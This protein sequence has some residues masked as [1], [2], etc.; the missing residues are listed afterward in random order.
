MTYR[1]LYPGIGQAVA[2]R[3]YLRKKTND[4]Y[5]NWGEVA[6][7]VALGNSLLCK[8][9]SEQKAEYEILKK[10][11]SNASILMSG[12]H[13]QHG[14]ESQPT[15][16]ME[17]FTNCSTSASCF[18]LFYLLMSGS[19]VGRCY[20]DDM[21]LVDWD[22]AP[23]LR[24]VL[25]D[26]H[27]DF[28]WSAHE[29]VR[30]AL[31]KYGPESKTV[32]WFKVPDSREG[33]AQAVEVWENAAF[34]KIHKDKT[35][36]LD[37]SDVRPKGSPIGGMQSRPSSGPIPLIN[38]L[39]K[40]ASL[41][42]SG[43]DPWKQNIY[44][45][46]YLAECVLVGGARRSA[47]MSTKFWK[48]ESIIDFIRVKR[49]IEFDGLS[50][51]E[52]LA[53]RKANPQTYGFL[54][55]SNNSVAVDEEFWK[56]LDLKRT[57]EAYGSPDAKWARKV[58]KE[59]INCS[60]ADG[61]GEP[62]IINVDK[63]VQ[64]NDGWQNLTG[65]SYV[66]SSKYQIREETEL[67]LGRLAKRAK[68]K[69]YNM[70]VNPC[71]EI[72]LSVLGG[73]CVIADVVPFHCDSLAEAREAFK[74]TTRAL[75]RV[76][77]MDA[78]YKKEVERT[79]RIGVGITGVHEFAWKFFK[80]GFRDLVNPNFEAIKNYTPEELENELETVTFDSISGKTNLGN[81][82]IRAALFWKCMEMFNGIVKAEAVAY[83]KKTGSN[84]PHT[85][86]TVKPSGTVSKLFGLTEGWHLPSMAFYLRWVQFRNDDPLVKEYEKSGYPV[87]KLKVYEGTTIIGFPTTL[88]IA[89]L[90]LG[91]KLVTAGEA[92][93][94]DQYKWLSL[95]E[96]YW[97]K[98]EGKDYGNQISY[99][100]KYNP[101][102]V[103]LKHFSDMLREHQKNIRCCS[104][105][106]Q[107]DQSSFE[108]LPEEMITKAKYEEIAHSIH[109]TLVE[110]ISFEHVD[111]EGG[112]C[113]IDFKIDKSAA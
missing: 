94:A 61:T 113:P 107:E 35:L 47:R 50:V 77:T 95:G 81:A 93:P 59:V 39:L 96:Q 108:Y 53:Y 100:L 60:Y 54:W 72:A 82:A 70:I 68:K 64:N 45:D 78:M 8:D 41:K 111:C 30:D 20:D 75:M 51:E 106:P 7:R 69:T 15:R 79:N 36:I 85:M 101:E 52:V 48:D 26:T 83:A 105:M 14:D 32:M 86:T 25:S 40:A 76:N 19:G 21:I 102:T 5:E 6:D 37:F 58:Y 10:H 97:I 63:L 42:G 18:V 112:A 29:S 99:T 65:H 34:E 12:R 89:E 28:D 38:A 62:G 91:D 57:D 16:P 104:V 92:T 66:G 84:I 3:T 22:N 31:H 98:G 44:I 71:G 9:P 56:L 1:N 46:H 67:F 49:P 11:I 43:I 13:L 110:D 17:V 88:A 4:E 87:R 103:D 109:K 55:S 73:Y 23:N 90:G 24:C 74:A 33:W 27:A 80:V 2:E